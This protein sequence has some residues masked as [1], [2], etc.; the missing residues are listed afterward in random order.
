MIDFQIG[1][2]LPRFLMEDK[3]GYALAK[4]IEKGLNMM[5]QTVETGL[6]I[7]T[8]MDMMPEWR[9]DEMAWELNCLYDFSAGVEEKREWIKNS[10]PLYSAYGTVQ[11]LY[12][13]LQGV[14]DYVFVEEWFKYAGQPY[15]YRIFVSGEWN[16]AK[17]AWARKA[18]E[19]AGNLRSVL[20]DIYAISEEPGSVELELSAEANVVEYPICG[21]FICGST[22]LQGGTP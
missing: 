3:N 19:R 8:N 9:L 2:L 4:A 22:I 21:A 7:T 14:F 11:A 20:E 10:V 5:C 1:E 15:H 6:N 16:P 17:E 13:Y 18:V 12:S